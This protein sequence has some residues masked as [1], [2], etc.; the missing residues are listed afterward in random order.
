MWLTAEVCS[1]LSMDMKRIVLIGTAIVVVAL[2]LY[3]PFVFRHGEEVVPVGHGWIGRPPDT[4]SPDG[5][6]MEVNA[7]VLIVEWL[8]VLLVAGLLL[9]ASRPV[10]KA[11]VPRTRIQAE[12]GRSGKPFPH[13]GSEDLMIP[14]IVA[15][16]MDERSRSIDQ[17][18][19]PAIWMFLGP[20]RVIR[21]ILGFIGAWQILG[22]VAGPLRYLSISEEVRVDAAE[23]F[24]VMG[25]KALICLIGLGSF[26]LLRWVINRGSKRRGEELPIQGFW[27]L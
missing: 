21:A 13:A 23:F 19:S 7:K 24:A 25:V 18:P 9:L 1:K 12:E 10:G 5:V 27:S 26:A 8:G 20:L 11:E 6:G 3:P 4:L 14:S 15:P 17:E 2:S 22:L 16:K